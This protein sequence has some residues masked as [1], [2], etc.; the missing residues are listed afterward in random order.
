MNSHHVVVA[1]T[2]SSSPS[3]NM[4]AGSCTHCT[5]CPTKGG[6]IVKQNSLGKHHLAMRRGFPCEVVCFG[7]RI[8][9]AAWRAR[10]KP[11]APRYPYDLSAATGMKLPKENER[12]QTR[13]SPRRRQSSVIRLSLCHD[14]QALEFFEDLLAVG[15]GDGVFGE[16]GEDEAE[17]V[18]GEAVGMGYQGVDFGPQ[19]VAAGVA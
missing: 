6:A 11:R 4:L 16:V 18:F 14:L 19:V 13:R 17:F 8:A 7:V 2:T 10:A 5:R 9:P 1:R 3:H 12:S 15:G